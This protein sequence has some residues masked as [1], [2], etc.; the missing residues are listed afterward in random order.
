[1]GTHGLISAVWMA[2]AAA[3]SSESDSDGDDCGAL[4]SGIDGVMSDGW[5]QV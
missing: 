2:R 5:R 1:M 4:L 3:A